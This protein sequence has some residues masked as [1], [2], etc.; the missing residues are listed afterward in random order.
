MCSN[1]TSI[2]CNATTPPKC[3]D[4]VSIGF[5]F[6]SC[7]LYVPQASI[8]QYKAAE[9]WKSFPNIY[10]LESTH[11]NSTSTPSIVATCNS[12]IITV[13]GLKAQENVTF[14]T[15]NGEQLGSAAAV[16]GTATFA[17]KASSD[18]VIAKFGGSS[19][20]IATK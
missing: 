11:M 6:S 8:A 13:S 4:D 5:N 14:Y 20:K 16:D 12:G 10:A 18:I 7:K 2:F 9:G 1:L 19:M 17:V 15:V 3:Y